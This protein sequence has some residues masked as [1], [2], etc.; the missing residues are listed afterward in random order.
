MVTMNPSCRQAAVHKCSF[1]KNIE[2]LEPVLFFE[3]LTRISM[4]EN[5]LEL[6]PIR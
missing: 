5:S 4:N 1:E 6:I 2:R 3:P